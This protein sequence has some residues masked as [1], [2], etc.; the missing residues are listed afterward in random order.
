MLMVSETLKVPRSRLFEFLFVPLLC[1]LGLS[2]DALNLHHDFVGQL[3]YALSYAILNS[4]LP[5]C[6]CIITQTQM[7]IHVQCSVT[8]LTTLLF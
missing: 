7:K 8:S 5:R 3:V 1:L 6:R 4:G 2:F